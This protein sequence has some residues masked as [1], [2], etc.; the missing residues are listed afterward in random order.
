[1]IFDILHMYDAIKYLFALVFGLYKRESFLKLITYTLTW[2]PFVHTCMIYMRDTHL[3]RRAAHTLHT[4][5]K[6]QQS[7]FNIRKQ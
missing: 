7:L 1:M 4:L 6:L 3:P 2:H 5:Y